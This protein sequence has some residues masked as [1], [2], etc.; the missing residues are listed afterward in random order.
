MRRTV[1][2]SSPPIRIT[3][4]DLKRAPSGMDLLV[5]SWREKA[6]ANG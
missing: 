1:A 4:E 6:R 5:A 3:R 2:V